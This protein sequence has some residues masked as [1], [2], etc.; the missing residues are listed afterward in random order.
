MAKPA[1]ENKDK[2]LEKQLWKAADKLRKNIDT[3][4]YKHVVMWLIFLKY[5]FDSFEKMFARLQ[6]GE[7]DI[8]KPLIADDNLIDCNVN[9][10][11]KRFLSTQIPAGSEMK[12]GCN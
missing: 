11:A 6:A 7:G 10:P 5:I 2:P 8:R 3:A 4:E 12:M 1:K 9:M